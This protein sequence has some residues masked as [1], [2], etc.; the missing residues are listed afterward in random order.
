MAS[1]GQN[2]STTSYSSS[3]NAFAHKL[4]YKVVKLSRPLFHLTVH[5]ATMATTGPA[6]HDVSAPS[7][8]PAEA[9]PWSFKRIRMAT[10]EDL[11]LAYTLISEYIQHPERAHCVEEFIVEP[12][13]PSLL[14]LKEPPVPTAPVAFDERTHSLIVRFAE[15]LG[16]PQE[17]TNVVLRALDLKK[18][19]LKGEEPDEPEPPAKRARFP[20]F[21]RRRGIP[22]YDS[23]ATMLLIAL[24]PNITNLRFYNV[25]SETPLGQFL[26]LNNYG[27][28]PRPFL[29]KLK[30]VQLHPL[31]PEDS[32]FYAYIR[33]LHDFRYVHRLPAVQ[34]FSLEGFEDYQPDETEFPRKTSGITKINIDHSDMSSAMIGG[35]M[36]IPRELHEFSLSIYGL[37]NTD[38]GTSLIDRRTIAKC[39]LEHRHCLN[40]LDLDATVGGPSYRCKEND[41]PL[42]DSSDE[43][44]EA[45][46]TQADAGAIGT[47]EWCLQ[48]DRKDSSHKRL[49]ADEPANRREYPARGIGRLHEFTALTHLSIVSG[50]LAPSMSRLGRMK[51]DCTMP[52]R[53]SVCF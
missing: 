12:G 46:D 30:H 4:R 32:R 51:A 34:S 45:P 16:L 3:I 42:F 39:L 40:V 10:S 31:N 11:L 49:W 1:Q 37:M 5:F 13:C 50:P 26:V 15:E 47:R 38:G 35:I 9:R 14:W 20:F 43:D 17:T 18:R 2:L 25:D 21:A 23:T 36:L 33:T 27:Q 53:G 6:A 24:C 28:L 48:Q 44:E 8:T 29:R 52:Y 7:S 41:D 19:E 22:N